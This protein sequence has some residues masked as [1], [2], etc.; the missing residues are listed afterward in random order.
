MLM[1]LITVLFQHVSSN[2]MCSRAVMCGLKAKMLNECLSAYR[3]FNFRALK[4]T[5]YYPLGSLYT[6]FDIWN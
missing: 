4:M 6:M 1:R 3:F 5:D 2:S